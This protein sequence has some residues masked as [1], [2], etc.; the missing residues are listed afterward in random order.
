MKSCKLITSGEAF[1]GKQGLSYFSGISAE[2]SGGPLCRA[3]RIGDV[4]RRAGAFY[5]DLITNDML[6]SRRVTEVAAEQEGVRCS[7]SFPWAGSGLMRG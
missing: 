5:H 3:E 2:S 4:R 6:S 1:D 7:K